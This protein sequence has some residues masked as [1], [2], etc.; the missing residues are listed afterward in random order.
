MRR[1][2]VLILLASSAL[3]LTSC[4]GN[5]VEWNADV[6]KASF[7]EVDS[8]FPALRESI[9]DL[10]ETINRRITTRRYKEEA[11]DDLKAITDFVDILQYYYMPVLNA[12]AMLSRAYREVELGMYT[13]A[14][15]DIGEAV[16]LV[17]RAA[18]KSTENTRVG[19][20]NVKEGLMDIGEISDANKQANLVKLS[21]AAK[22]LNLLIERIQP[23]VVVT[24]EGESLIEG[25]M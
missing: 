3:I 25:H 9:M 19:F 10:D 23:T 12:R 4:G 8:A 14:K 11:L 18:L 21:N 13:E 2:V 24:E 5:K 15:D 7:T 22:K 6:E 17:N 20:E 16:D 1:V